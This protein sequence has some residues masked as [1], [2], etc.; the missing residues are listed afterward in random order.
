MKFLPLPR[1]KRRLLDPLGRTALTCLLTAGSF[2]GLCAPLPLALTA[3]AGPGLPGLCCVLGCGA[4]AFLFLPFQAGLRQLAAAILIFSGSIAFYDTRLFA[5]RA[6]RPGLAAA[7][8]LL[9]QSAYLIARPAQLWGL[10]G[11]CMAAA[12]AV[13]DL[14]LRRRD[15]LPLLLAVGVCLAAGRVSLSGV[16]PGMCLAAALL[17]RSVREL[18]PVRAAAWGAAVGLCMGLLGD[19]PDPAPMAVLSLSCAALSRVRP[20]PV[21][22]RIGTFCAVGAGCVLLLGMA[23]PL[24]RVIELA[25]GGMLSL[26]PLPRLTPAAEKKEPQPEKRPLQDRFAKPAAALRD[27]Y[28]SFFRGTAPEKPENPS[29]LFDRAAEQVC[30]RCILRD[31]CWRQNYGATYNAFNDACPQ[32][33]RR[34]QALP[35][36][37]PLYFTSRCVHLTEFVEAVNLELRSYLLRQQYHRRLSE[38]RDQAREQYAQL[39]D[40]LASAGPAVPTSAQAMGYRVASS[41]RPREGQN[42]CGDQLDSFEVGGAVYLLLSD[43]MG[44]GE[45]AHREAAM[46]VRLLRQF[47]EAG[48]EPGPALKTLNTALSLRGESGGG[49]T[50]IDLL[51]LQRSS[52]QAALYKYGAAPSYCKRGGSVSRYAGQ[53]LPA[54]LQAVRDAPECTR[55]QLTAGSFFVMVS[56]GIAD[57]GNDEWLQNLLAGWSGRDVNALVSLILAESRGRKG[58]EDD[59]AVLA[60]HLSSGEKKPV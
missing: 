5:R 9:V 18:E 48:I 42:V 23:E 39:G 40:L 20:A 28:D 44:S 32:L 51:A 17:I 16:S 3:A 12:A 8:L 24:Y 59:C 13:T 29:V 14:L 25:S 45:A 60:L 55:L 46:T 21:P 38:V 7:L 37:F 43:G 11:F 54:G 27:L 30:R 10:C 1:E 6:F 53:S 41:L 26:L 2:G 52:G 47:L 36:D 19:A 33:L 15:R 57:A 49:F 31:T 35:G 4:G 50:T 56:D 22:V 58:L 34:G